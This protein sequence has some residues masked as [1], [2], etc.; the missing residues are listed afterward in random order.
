MGAA[1][2]FLLTQTWSGPWRSHIPPVFPLISRSP[3][4]ALLPPRA[5]AAAWLPAATARSDNEAPQS[6]GR[7]PSAAADAVFRQTIKRADLLFGEVGG[8]SGCCRGRRSEAPPI[9]VWEPTENFSSSQRRI[10]GFRLRPGSLSSGLSGEFLV[11]DCPQ[12]DVRSA[13]R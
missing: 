3:P 12:T 4:D 2:D 6:G 8:Q 1:G 7:C 9:L 5:A 11:S 10:G 13:P